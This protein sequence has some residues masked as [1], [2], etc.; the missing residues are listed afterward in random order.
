M[1]SPFRTSTPTPLASITK[2]AQAC[3]N[4]LTVEHQRLHADG[5]REENWKRWGPYLSERQ[6]GTVREDYSSDGETWQH[7]PHDHARSRAYRWGE[8]GLLGITDRQC[9][10]CFSWALWNGKDPILKERLFGLTGLEG[11]HG[12]DVKE[13]YYY[14]DSTPTHS[15]MRALYKYPQAEYPYDRLVEE[16]KSRNR[17]QPEYEIEDTGIFERQR[18]FD[19]HVTYAKQSA[20]HILIQADIV[21]RGD[22]EAHL[23]VLPTAWFRNTWS[24]PTQHERH[25]DRPNMEWCQEHQGVRM[26]H[27]DLA[28]PYYMTCDQPVV[29]ADANRM[30]VGDLPYFHDA[31]S[32]GGPPVG[33]Q[34]NPK[35]P[36]WLF[37]ENETNKERLY[38]QRDGVHYS[39]DAFHRYVVNGERNAVNPQATGTK[40]ACSIALTIPAG[41]LAQVRLRLYAK[42]EQADAGFGPSFSQILR[43]RKQ[44]ADQFYQEKQP[45]ELSPDLKAIQRQ[46]DA[47]LLWTKQFY[48]YVV[49][50]WLDDQRTEPDG[51]PANRTVLRNADWPQLFNRDIIS[52]PDKWEY[53]WFAAWDLAFHMLPMANLDPDFAKR[54]LILFLREWYMHPNGQIP[55]YEWALGDVNPPVHAWA[56]WRVFEI[57]RQDEVCDL[58]FLKRVFQ[59]LLLNFT[60]WVNRKDVR[61]KN[62]FSGGFL[63]LD[64]I[65][66]FDRSKPLPTGGFLEQADGTA[67][68]AFFCRNMLTMALQLGQDH[69]AY[70]DVASKFFEHYVGIA[71][72]MNT[73][74]GRGLWD[75]ED[76]FYY[77][78]LLHDGQAIP[79]KVRSIVGLLPLLAVQ[80][81]QD[82]SLEELPGFTRR[83]N[84]FLDYHKDLHLRM[85]YLERET[86]H[87]EQTGETGQMRLLAIPSQERLKRLLNYMLDE[88]EFLCPF[89]IRSLSKFH[90]EN[91]YTFNVNGEEHRVAYV[92]GESDSWMFG[93]NS[94]WRG[95]VWFPL[96]YLIIEALERYHQFYGDSLK[97]ECPVGSGNFLNLGEVATELQNR[98]LKLFK[99]NDQGQRPSQPTDS[100]FPQDP[101]FEDLILFHEYFHAETGQGLGASHQTGWTSLVSEIIDRLA[102]R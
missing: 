83:M 38:G 49:S 82:R 31:T 17:L 6:W 21:N 89:G 40:A 63:G 11:N 15:F 58:D 51:D 30:K 72:A 50:E 61:G 47:G 64:N 19:F 93:G 81:M 39:K 33:S 18:Y 90:L 53:P 37:T 74:D 70:S 29:Y 3:S 14:L 66:I 95:P 7:F 44:E 22:H 34:A 55:A 99:I 52:M 10:L 20:N 68:M 92:P 76:G 96:N 43:Q 27:S 69:Q 101:N 36:E 67:W 32:A 84:W 80:V 2:S 1:S 77:D 56:C 12:E 35:S 88:K 65:G 54:Q 73:A 59:K 78:H 75:E 71:E 100:R 48:H 16:S 24:W 26:R 87:D 42:T 57:T 46:S 102:A 62:L 23:Q 91:P 13:L 8:D 5:L 86:G 45:P 4:C 79:L 85:T 98:L 28:Q 41:G 94:N 97:V 9:R 25:W 60:W